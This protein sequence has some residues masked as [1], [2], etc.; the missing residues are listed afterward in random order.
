MPS[1]GLESV[2]PVPWPFTLLCASFTGGGASR[3]LEKFGVGW[4]RQA[5]A[6][7]CVIV[8][9]FSCMNFA[10]GVLTSQVRRQ[11]VGYSAADS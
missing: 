8:C 9:L 2:V 7:R 1:D 10:L 3:A 6:A 4:G 11:A 5:G